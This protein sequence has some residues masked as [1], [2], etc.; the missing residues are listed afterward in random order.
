M[1]IGDDKNKIYKL[2]IEYNSDTEEIEY[3]EEAIID[4]VDLDAHIRG[5]VDLE[6]YGWDE[7]T[8]EYMRE[9]Y[10]SGEA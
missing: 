9:H 10:M 7:D 1:A 8:L 6:E 4:N 3:I 5:K 2:T